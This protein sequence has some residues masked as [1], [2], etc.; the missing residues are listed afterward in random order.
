MGLSVH[1]E[2]HERREEVLTMYCKVILI[3]RPLD[4]LTYEAVEGVCVGAVVQVPVKSSSAT[5]IV[6]EVMADKGGISG[7]RKCLKLLSNAR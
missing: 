7:R 5:G 2:R 4:P 3:D 1:G 6:V